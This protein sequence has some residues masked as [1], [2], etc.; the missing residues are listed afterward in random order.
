MSLFLPVVIGSGDVDGVVPITGTRAWLQQ[1]EDEGRLVLSD[2][3]APW[4]LDNQVGPTALPFFR[5]GEDVLHESFRKFGFECKGVGIGVGGGGWEQVGGYSEGYNEGRFLF[6]TVRNAGHM[7]PYTQP[8][9]ALKLF[10]HFLKSSAAT[11]AAFENSRR[12]LTAAAK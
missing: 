3:W 4:Y 11:H 6:W 9:R 5:I 2:K 12:R 7:V 10:S 1:L 8:A